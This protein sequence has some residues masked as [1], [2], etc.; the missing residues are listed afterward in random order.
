MIKR[1][2][3]SVLIALLP[4]LGL[5]QTSSD[6]TIVTVTDTTADGRVFYVD[7]IWDDTHGTMLRTDRV[8]MDIIREIYAKRKEAERTKDSLRVENQLLV[9]NFNDCEKAKEEAE[10][11]ITEKDK[12]LE[13]KQQML[14]NSDKSNSLADTDIKNLNNKVKVGKVG[15]SFAGIFFGVAVV[16]TVILILRK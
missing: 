13:L 11:K 3:I 6:S 8:G 4:L 12:Q 5:S 2:L 16:E 9:E 14:D 10:K 15:W 7:L 1:S